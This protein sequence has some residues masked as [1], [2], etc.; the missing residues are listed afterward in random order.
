MLR[1]QKGGAPVEVDWD[2][3]TGRWLAQKFVVAPGRDIGACVLGGEFVGAFY[4]VAADGEWMTTTSSGGRYAHCEL[5]ADGQ[6]IA[7]SA[8]SLFNLDYTVVDLVEGEGGYQLYEVSAFGGF[9]GL[10]AACQ[11]DVARLY[12]QYVRRELRL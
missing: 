7:I 1:L 4:R 2:D 12:A 11:L 9:S 10:R 5:S 3:D 6:A 8:A